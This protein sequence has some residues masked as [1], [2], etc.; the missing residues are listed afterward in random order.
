MSVLNQ[1]L[2]AKIHKVSQNR[3]V[4]FKNCHNRIIS[5]VYVIMQSFPPTFILRHQ[6][7]N[8]KKCSLRGLEKRADC[9]FFTYPTSVLPD[10]AGYL[11]LAV[12]APP[13]LP[14]D[15]GQGLFLL[16]ATWRYA[17]K[18]LQFVES[19]VAIERRS[20]PKG[21][22]TA[23]PRCQN[24][25]PNPDEGLAS[26]EALYVAYL[27]LGRNPEGLLDGYYWKD[28]FLEKNKEL[29]ASSERV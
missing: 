7:E 29:L 17:A 25:C 5:D 28:Q 27:V 24:D 19:K 1:G 8:L 23:Y 4:F 6:R 15:S 3:D 18:M 22:R 26:V 9:R 14:S 11:L 13:L 20:I 12:E 10:T 2:L 21:F 16:D